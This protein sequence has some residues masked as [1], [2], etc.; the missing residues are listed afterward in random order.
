MR[1]LRLKR[2]ID[3][4]G[5]GVG[6]CVAAPLLVG[7]ATFIRL[8]MG[9]PVL[10]RQRRPGLHE[11]PFVMLKFRTM[12]DAVDS[13]GRALPDNQ[14]LTRLGTLLRATSLDELPELLNVLRGEM[15]LVGPRPLLVEYLPLY[16][17]NQR[18][19]HEVKPGI[20]GWAQVNGRNGLDWDQKFAL[21]AWYVD[22]WSNELDMKILFATILAV[23]RRDGI[24]HEA[25]A[26][27]PKFAGRKTNGSG[28]RITP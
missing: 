7:V 23:L 10:F 14:R 17:E 22:N 20:T 15:S 2:W 3:V 1:S 12:A 13:N 27:M 21:D 18:R 9:S 19:R 16:D 8:T 5:A 4:A 26:T 6:L 11:E 24:S 28:K 25:H